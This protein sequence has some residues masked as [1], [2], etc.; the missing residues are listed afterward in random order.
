ME[1][2][3]ANGNL[4]VG[5]VDVEWLGSDDITPSDVDPTSV[6]LLFLF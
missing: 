6:S 2:W 1:T 4:P 5:V 3:V